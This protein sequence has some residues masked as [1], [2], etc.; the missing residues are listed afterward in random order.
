M[1]YLSLF[2]FIRS[3]TYAFGY[4][5]DTIEKKAEKKILLFLKDTAETF[6]MK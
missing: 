3:F 4:I 2:I 6:A 5:S 1:Y